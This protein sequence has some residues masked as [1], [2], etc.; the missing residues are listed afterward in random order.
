MARQRRRRP[1]GMGSVYQRGPA[2]WWIKWRE[3]GRVRYS[4][5]YA[6]RELAERV[7]DKII[8]DLAAGRAGLPS[9]EQTAPLLGDLATDW[10]VRRS[11]THRAARVDRGRWRN[12]LGP[13]FGS[14]RPNDVNPATIRSFVEAKLAAG[15]NPATVGHCFRLLS[16]FF[17]DLVER[18]LASANPARMVPRSTRR[19][20]K[21]TADPHDTPFLQRLEDVRRVYLALGEPYSVAFAVG[22]FAGLRTGE[23]L[24]LDWRNVD[25]TARRIYVRVQMREG[26]LAPLK[27][28]E[29]RIVPILNPLVPILAAWKLKT[30][31]KA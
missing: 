7:R 17:A 20:F 24:G 27:D 23:V 12:H 19:L 22:A 21:P 10:L 26:R 13:F 6:T 30:G 3:G 18:G 31:G 2:N 1:H 5:G 28:S 4:H 14:Y 29:S 15:M 16:T 9:D 11:A 8:A 25:L